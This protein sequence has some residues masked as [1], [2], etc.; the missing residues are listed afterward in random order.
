MFNCVKLIISLAAVCM[1]PACCW[2]K[3][4]KRCHPCPTCSD[5]Q[6]THEPQPERHMIESEVSSSSQEKVAPHHELME[7]EDSPVIII[8]D[9][10][11]DD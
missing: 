7:E 2:S 6:I 8:E 4:L 3:C 1:L 11:I 5:E 10:N 9:E